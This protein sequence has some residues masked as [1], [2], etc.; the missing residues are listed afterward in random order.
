MD[1]YC[2]D[3]YQLHV[4][5]IEVLDGV[6]KEPAKKPVKKGPAKKGPVKKEP[7]K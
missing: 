2:V 5:Y 6:K 7:G 4:D 3:I 1:G